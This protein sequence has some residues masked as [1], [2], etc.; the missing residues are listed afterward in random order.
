MKI[1]TFW[2]CDKHDQLTRKFYH[3]KAQE[4]TAVAVVEAAGGQA[5]ARNTW[6][7]EPNAAAVVEFCNTMLQLKEYLET[8]PEIE[9]EIEDML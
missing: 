8:E 4:Q 3:T 7:I 2:S 9:P 1:Y 5:L 6:D